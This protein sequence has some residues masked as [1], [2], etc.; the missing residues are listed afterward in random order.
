M[1]AKLII[2]DW[3]GTLMDSISKIIQC[4][5]LA[6]DQVGVKRVSDKNARSIIGLSLYKAMQVLYPNAPVATWQSL[7]EAYQ[8]QFKYVDTTPTPLFIG[9]KELLTLLKDHGFIL[10]IATGK[11]RKGLDKMLLSSGL[12]AFFSLTRTADDAESKPSP[13]MLLQILGALQIKPQDAIMVGDSL[14]DIKMA[15]AAG[16]KPV[17]MSWGAM[18]FDDLVHHSVDTVCKNITELK[19]VLLA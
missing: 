8:Y 5:Y 15:T 19:Q 7:V 1:T 17:A 10:A 13:D 6:A 4:V 3:D 11:S 9:I 16:V 2:F 14:L 18:S 12:D